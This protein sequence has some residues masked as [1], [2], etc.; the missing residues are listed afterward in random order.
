MSADLG[1][2]LAKLDNPFIESPVEKANAKMVAGHPEEALS[3]IL[4]DA[5]CPSEAIDNLAEVRQTHPGIIDK[6]IEE[7]LNKLGE[8]D[9]LYLFDVTLDRIDSLHSCGIIETDRQKQVQDQIMKIAAD[10]VTS[11][12]FARW[13][14]GRTWDALPENIH[15]K[16]FANA[17]EDEVKRKSAQNQSPSGRLGMP[18]HRIAELNPRLID[19]NE[20]ALV[21]LAPFA[22][23][24]AGSLA[25]GV[26][27]TRPDFAARIR[28]RINDVERDAEIRRQARIL[29][30][31][32]EVSGGDAVLTREMKNELAKR[33]TLQPV[34]LGQEP[35]IR[36]EIAIDRMRYDQTASG[37]QTV[38]YQDY[39]V[40]LLG[41][42]LLMPRNAVY[43]YDVLSESA[44][45]EYAASVRLLTPEGELIDED[46]VTGTVSSTSAQCQDAR[47]R[48]V[49]GGVQPAGFIANDDM[50]R[51]CGGSSA[52]VKSR[53]SLE[54]EALSRMARDIEVQA[55]PHLR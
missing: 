30:F 33:R 39:Q 10:R 29:D 50:Q 34:Q 41:A 31:V 18:L 23:G 14:S 17:V 26:F 9:E 19:G 4:P 20:D 2:R 25:N 5:N 16:A 43:E 22:K 12:G 45:L 49:F 35:E 15:R 44:H 13:G 1:Q 47:I 48:N 55:R 32:V 42:I 54:S 36:I 37:P 3:I 6:A 8:T 7:K 51:R 11:P 46:L 24:D 52:S 53:S 40:N 38:R 21:S 28:Q 27:A